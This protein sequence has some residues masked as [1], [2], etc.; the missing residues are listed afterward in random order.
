MV[1]ADHGLTE[2]MTWFWHGHWATAV[3]KVQYALPMYQQNQVLRNTALGNFETQARQM[4]VDSAMLFWLD[5]NSN[6]AKSPNEN[7]ARVYGALHSRC[8]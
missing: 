4:I 6:V 5:G 2:R 3:G 7:L 8:R 1:S